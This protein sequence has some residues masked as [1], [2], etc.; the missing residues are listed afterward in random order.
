MHAAAFLFA[1]HASL[2]LSR[3][4][5]SAALSMATRRFPTSQSGRLSYGS[6]LAGQQRQSATWHR[7]MV[8]CTAAGNGGD[9]PRNLSACRSQAGRPSFGGQRGETSWPQPSSI[10]QNLWKSNQ[11][12]GHAKA[13]HLH[14]QPVC[15][16]LNA[17]AYAHP[18]NW[19]VKRTPILAS[20]YWFPACFALRCRLPWALGLKNNEAT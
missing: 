9:V 2:H 3:F 20:K 17:L 1:A 13:K 11:G 8:T 15:R 14:A 16:G 10:R 19:A 12:S 7:Q 6:L 18:P 5:A 4:G